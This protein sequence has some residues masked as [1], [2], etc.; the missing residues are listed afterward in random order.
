MITE[1]FPIPAVVTVSLI[2]HLMTHKIAVTAENVLSALEE[3]AILAEMAVAVEATH[4]HSDYSSNAGLRTSRGGGV[5][6]ISS[7]AAMVRRF[8]LET[9]CGSSQSYL[10]FL[11]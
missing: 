4:E 1:A 2:N 8:G 3:H 9:A 5:E 11:L 10:P 7:G 6:P